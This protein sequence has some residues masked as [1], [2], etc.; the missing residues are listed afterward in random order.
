N[1]DIN[2]GNI[3]NAYG[4]GNQGVVTTT[5]IRVDG[6]TIGSV[7][8]GGNQAIATT[9]HVDLY[10][11]TVTD[12][13]GGG[14]Q[15]GTSETNVVAHIGSS[16]TNVYGGSNQSGNNTTTNVSI[17]PITNYYDDYSSSGS[18]LNVSFNYRFSSAQYQTDLYPEYKTIVDITPVFSST[19]GED[20]DEWS[21]TLN[22]P[23]ST[24]FSNDGDA[25]VIV[26]GESYTWNQDDRWWGTN[27]IPANSTYSPSLPLRVLIKGTESDFNLIYDLEAIDGDGGVHKKTNDPNYVSPSMG[28][29][30]NITNVYGG[31]NQGGNN[32]TTNVIVDSGTIGSVYGGNNRGGTST[33]TNVTINGSSISELY[34]GGNLAPVGT[35]NVSVTDGIITTAYG[36]G[37][38]ANTTTANVSI[39]GGTTTTL[40][41][42]GNQ[43]TVGTTD[44]DMTNGTV[45]T[46]YGGGNLATVG[47]TDVDMTNGTVGTLYGGGNQA[48]VNSTDVDILGGTITSNVFGGGNQGVVTGSTNVL[49]NDANINGSAYAGGNGAS[50]VVSGNTTITV[51]GDTVIGTSS[52]TLPS[53][54]SLFG[55]GNAAETGTST[56]NNSV[57]TVNLAGGTIHGNVY[58]GANT[59]VVHGGTVLNIGADSPTPTGIERDDILINGTVFG[60]GEANAS[61]STTYDYSFISVTG[62]I[63]VNINGQNYTNLDVKGSVF[64]SGNASSSM[65]TSEINIYNYGTPDAP[66]DNISVQRTGTLTIDNSAIRLE[67]ATDR[68]NEYSNVEFSLSRIDVLNLQNNSTIY[69]RNGTN[70]LKQFNSLTANGQKATVT[71]NDTTKTVTKNVDN[72][73]YVYQGIN[74]NIAS[75]EGVNIS[76][77]YGPVNGMTFFGMYMVNEHDDGVITGIYGNYGYGDVVSWNAAFTKGSYVLGQHKSNHNTEV[78]GF[79]SNYVDAVTGVNTVK[80]IETTPPDSDY[81]IWQIGD[82]V[83]EYTIELV[84]SK[85]ST[86]SAIEVPFSDFAAAN[87]SFTILG[88]DYTNL[89]AGINLIDKN[90]IPK[91]AATTNDADSNFGLAIEA[92]EAGWLTTGSTNFY[93][94]PNNQMSGKTNYVGDSTNNVP[95]L[96]FYLYHSKNFGTTADMGRASINLVAITKIDDLNSEVQRFIINVDMSRVLFTDNNYEGAMTTGRKYELFSSTA[97]NISSKSSISAYYSLYVE[98]QNVYRTGYKRALVSNYALPENTKITMIDISG[99]SPKY[100]YHIITAAEET[101]AAQAI[102]TDTEASYPLSMFEV[103]GAFNSGSYYD[104]AAMNAAYYNATGNYDYEE[105]IFIVDFADTNIDTTS[106][107]NSLLFELQNA[108]GESIIGVLGI[109]HS[110]MLYNIYADRDALIDLEGTI[111]KNDIYAGETVL[112]NINTNYTQYQSAGII[113][114]D[115]SH[116][117]DKLGLEISILDENGTIVPGTSMMGLYY[118][119]DGSRYFPNVDGTT[120]IK[121]ADKVGNVETWI[122]LATG[123]SNIATGDYTIRIA[124]FAS[125]DGLYYGIDTSDVL[126]FPVHIINEIYGLKVTTNPENLV[127]DKTTG[128]NLLGSAATSFTV[129]YNSGL[130]NPSIHVRMNRREYDEIYDTGYTAVNLYDYV[131]NIS[132]ARVD[133]NYVMI[134][135]PQATN[136]ITLEYKPGLLNGT[137]KLE[138]M[139]YDSNSLIGTVEKYVIIK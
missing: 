121:I 109:Q 89:E 24:F 33:T 129:E 80:Y 5:N 74:V 86:L 78:D 12:T 42:G 56:T 47:T 71:I 93:T 9:T 111:S 1:V 14:N 53:T 57:A 20:Y 36:G 32:A 134:S 104:D 139:L 69:L 87:T 130:T 97:T 96:L 83:K 15:A 64:G 28:G 27:P 138:F 49:I 92:S 133:G 113:T 23:N 120:R 72:R 52:C 59:S 102:Q 51:G 17:G 60:G 62:S 22:V 77:G 7:F 44:V 39:S 116:I 137:Y 29:G 91:V 38:Q 31:S 8:G 135:N 19:I 13:Y 90:S 105:F 125:P 110:N 16:S 79:Y 25:N 81:Y 73:V 100:Y 85:Y 122:R 40:Y 126:N 118:D 76:G 108:T 68:T 98:G 3:T 82:S 4:G 88:V 70:L 114:Y 119:I 2:N 10:G 55:G 41:G 99:D 6:G 106:L 136:T 101:A 58:G 26:N 94:D 127:I 95:T 30:V 103:M 128:L 61:G 124:S 48:G 115:T 45:T 107:Q 67:G 84:A 21:V 43:G 117:G 63:I 18:G 54:C 46:L 123:T 66:K 50:A 35:S 132:E 34:G 37:N 131:S 75:Q 65:G 11:G 112:L